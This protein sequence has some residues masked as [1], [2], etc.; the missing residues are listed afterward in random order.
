MCVYVCVCVCVFVC[1]YSH[2]NKRTHSLSQMSIITQ[3]QRTI[4]RKSALGLGIRTWVATLA[5]KCTSSGRSSGN[6]FRSHLYMHVHS[7]IAPHIF[8]T[9]IL[10][11]HQGITSS[12]VSYIH[13]YDLGYLCMCVYI[14]V[15]VYTNT[16]THTHKNIYLVNILNILFKYSLVNV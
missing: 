14:Y 6:L 2:T 12:D 9:I 13:I 11:S 7:T 4:L 8:W 1:V 15:N 3:V 16:Q 5:P 10:Q